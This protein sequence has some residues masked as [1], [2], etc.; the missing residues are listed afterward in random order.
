M[1]DSNR[2]VDLVWAGISGAAL[3]LIFILLVDAGALISLVVGAAGFFRVKRKSPPTKPAAPTTREM[4]AP[5]STRR[6]KMRKRA[7]PL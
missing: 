3:F 6:M 7:A 1:S 5:A 4:R 2:T